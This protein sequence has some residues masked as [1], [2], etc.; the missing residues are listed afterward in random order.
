MF[1]ESRRTT[2]AVQA[3]RVTLRALVFALSF[4]LACLMH[5]NP[6]PASAGGWA[7][8]ATVEPPEDVRAGIET[9]IVLEVKQHGQTLIN[10]ERPMLSAINTDTGER[11]SATAVPS[12]TYGLYNASVTFPSAGEWSWAVTLAQ[13]AIVDSEFA[14]IVVTDVDTTPAA[15]QE[16]DGGSSAAA[17][18][19]TAEE[20]GHLSEKLSSLQTTIGI[21]QADLN[22]SVAEQ[23]ALRTELADLRSNADA[24]ATTTRWLQAGLVIVSVLL[25][26]VVV[27]GG[28]LLRR[29]EHAADAAAAAPDT[30]PARER[31][32]AD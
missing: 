7:T 15:A 17:Q 27:V 1:P 3:R 5:F 31:V 20:V 11:V 18:A 25:V 10:W 8:V 4:L 13:L 30:T 12:D 14:P 24:T 22:A 23:T 9:T 28:L 32:L 29:R 26:A 2:T 19:A 6:A 21:L 16:S